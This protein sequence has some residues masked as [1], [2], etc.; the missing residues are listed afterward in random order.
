MNFNEDKWTQPE[1]YNPGRFI[2]EGKFQKPG[3]F[4]PFSFGKRQCMGYRITD[5]LTTFIIATLLDKFEIKC[6]QD[7]RNQPVGQLGLAPEPFYFTL[8]TR[9][10]SNKIPNL[11]RMTA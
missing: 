6:H 5:Y 7:M 10:I 3:H 1:L 9:E 4:H 11:A 8:R 2:K